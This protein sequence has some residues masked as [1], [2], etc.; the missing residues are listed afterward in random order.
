[1][2]GKSNNTQ[3]RP[4]QAPKR[5][6]NYPAEE[7]GGYELAG[8]TYIVF[9]IL[10]GVLMYGKYDAAIPEFVQLI[11]SGIFGWCAVLAPVILIGE[12]IYIMRVKNF[13]R[14]YFKM[15]MVFL[16]LF[17]LCILSSLFA[18]PEGIPN[19]F[20]VLADK[21]GYSGGGFLGSLVA[22]PF[23]NLL[24]V[25]P[26][27]II[28]LMLFVMLL[29]VVFKF[30]PIRMIMGFTRKVR[31]E[32]REID[33]E[34]SYE[35]GQRARERMEESIEKMNRRKKQ[36][37]DF[38]VHDY[39]EPKAGKKRADSA[40]KREVEEAIDAERENSNRSAQSD[41]DSDIF[42]ANG[43]LK[44]KKKNRPQEPAP[45]IKINRNDDVDLYDDAPEDELDFDSV[46]IIAGDSVQ[47]KAAEKQSEQKPK[48]ARQMTDSQQ[49]EYNIELDGKVKHRVIPYKFPSGTLLSPAKNKKTV[50]PRG[51][52]RE[53]ANKLVATL[54]SFGVDVTLLQVSR[55]PTV[56]RYELQ[57][58]VGVKVSK[59]TSLA[60]DI[61]LNLAAPSVRIEAPIPGKAA[62]GIEIP[63][64][65]ISSV[66]LRDVLDSDEFKDSESKVSVALG[67]DIAG[68]S[69]IAN[70]AKMPHVLIAGA[71]GSGK[72]V[73]I[74]SLIISIL[75]KANPNEV[76]FVMIDPK[77]VE[78]LPYNGIPHLLTPVVT[79]PK[80][81]SGALNWAVAEM[82]RRYDLFAESG[83]RDLAGYNA[84]A[85]LEGEDKLPQIV[86]IIDE[87]A[88]LMMVAPKEVEDAICR[89]AQLARACGMHLVIATQRPS[90]NVITGIIKANIPSRIAFA[91]TS[92][93]DSRTILDGAGAEKLLG[94]GDMLYMPMGASKALRL[95]GSFISDAEVEKVV[96][97][98]KDTS[99][100]GYDEEI[101]IKI[102][103][104]GE[105]ADVSGD[106][107]E[108][109]PR[110]IELA[111]AAGQISTSMLQRRLG[112]GY[113]RAGRIVDQME[114]RGIISGAD[115]S[116]PRNVLIS[117]E[118]LEIQ[119]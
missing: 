20:S 86:I 65:E 108:L 19:A 87:L 100:T 82:T 14:L 68:K 117:A 101:G 95:Q 35:M 91:V 11:M 15:L 80:K 43:P 69:V 30:S 49:A 34:R 52:L 115:G 48:R 16:A 17:N 53:T 98:I 61:A 12:G 21:S 39:K 89:L 27:I 88:D 106:A 36:Q 13:G 47:E 1:M 50:D 9:G 44:R 37:I 60:D 64:K 5:G 57:P 78:L 26:T 74:N 55:G 114:A 58:N 97:F 4:Q 76:K 31:D 111:L 18:N 90:V 46:T 103:S 116:K 42:R 92:Q 8:V 110:A 22:T 66:A 81:A 73:C 41:I 59:I 7:H 25:V 75:Y 24:T 71:T 84:Y 112:I 40:K 77:R 113:A 96:S 105:V 85:E 45:E 118:D 10:L 2:A 28:F 109:L 93:I 6:A 63:N 62:I 54:K 72:S 23:V 94:K 107:D 33:E 32:V 3:K 56:T 104:G 119:E 70:I 38:E 99:T 83:V 29:V 51:E 67:M 79:D 102:N